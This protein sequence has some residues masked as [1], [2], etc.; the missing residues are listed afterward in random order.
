MPLKFIYSPL[1]VAFFTQLPQ[2]AES[3]VL[4]ISWVS[5][6]HAQDPANFCMPCRSAGQKMGLQAMK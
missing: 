1:F 6:A 5:I 4:T 2:L 3:P